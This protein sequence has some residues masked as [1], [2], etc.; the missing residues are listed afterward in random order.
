MT[1][2]QEVE[3][4]FLDQLEALGWLVIDQ[5][6][7]S[8]EPP[9]DPTASERYSFREVVLAERFKEAVRDINR[10]E[11]G[12]TWLTN[13]QLEQVLSEVKSVRCTSGLVDTNE[14][15]LQLLF[16]GAR[17]DENEVTGQ[18]SPPVH[19][20]D[21]QNPER[22]DFLAINQFRVDVPHGVKP[23]IIPDIV[24]FVNGLPLVVVE[25]KSPD[26]VAADALH[27]AFQQLMRYSDQRPETESA[28]LR[29][30]EPRLFQTNQLLIR[31]SGEYA[32]YGSITATDPEFFFPW[33]DIIPE[34][35]QDY[36]PPLGRERS[37]EVLIQGMLP[38]AT[39]LD[40]MRT[41]TVFMNSGPKRIKVV[42]RYQQ[43]RAVHRMVQR[44]RDGQTPQERSGV[45]WH[46]QGS[47]KSLTMVFLIRK[48]RVSEDLKDYKVLLVNDRR[49]LEK[50][51]GDTAALTGER[52]NWVESTN[53]LRNKLSTP[54]SDLNLVMIHKFHEEEDRTPGYMRDYS[55]NY[56]IAADSSVPEY[57]TFGTVN[58]SDRVLIL[59]DEAHR[60]QY[61]DMGD[62]L[63]EA[64]PNATRI[65][66]TGTPLI[67]RRGQKQLTHERF[68]SYIDK[69]KVQDAVDD[70]VT[71]QI[72][73]EGRTAET[74]ITH[75]HEFDT[76]FEDLFAERSDEEIQKIKKKYGTT[77]DILEAQARI[78][79]VAEDLVD[80]YIEHILPNGFKA[81][82]VANSKLAAVRYEQYIHKAL[83]NRIKQEK[84]KD[85]P[86]LNHVA[87][88]SF[89]D[90]A[91]VVSA[92]GTNER[93]EVVDADRRTRSKNAVDNFLKA[94]DR[95]I[96]ETGMAFLCVCDRLLT[97]FDAPIEQ[98]MYIDKK[99]RDH[100]LLQT[101]ARVNRVSEDKTRGY[102]VDY[103]G[104]AHHLKEMLSIYGGGEDQK[105]AEA[106]LQP[107]ENEVPLLEQRYRRLIQ[108]F[109]AGNVG[110]IESFA[111]QTLDSQEEAETI[112][113]AAI[114]YLADVEL[115]AEFEVYFKE[116]M[117]SL[118]IILPN[119]AGH[120]Y[121]IPAK[122]FGYINA[123]AKQRYK[124]E[125]LNL[126]GAGEKVKRLVD[127]HLVS[128]GIDPKIPPRELFSNDFIQE[129]EERENPRAKASEMEHA[130]RKH[131]KVHMEEDPALYRRLS[132]KLEQLIQQYHQ[133]W[134]R[135]YQEL[136]GLREEAQQ[137]RR[138]GEF[139]D[140]SAQEAPFYELIKIHAFGEQELS[141]KE[142][143]ALRKLV[144]A[145]FEEL[146]RTIGRVNFWQKPADVQALRGKLTQR[147]LTS[148]LEQVTNNRHQIAT[149]LVELAKNRERDILG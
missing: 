92:G 137:G 99:V 142:H 36:T 28:G 130:I 127:E 45:V 118:D 85:L 72:L 10:T 31:I 7:G 40:L 108:F 102:I 23:F 128:L 49:D 33:R 6:T 91:T 29:E 67:V 124:D 60:S 100:N 143:E 32:E 119:P 11:D 145:V 140:V 42:A 117:R 34:S 12:R 107:V 62:N 101:I 120:E 129:M 58:E 97:G 46:T 114:A 64:F 75:R 95:D 4:P 103:I 17:V 63:F 37:Q 93:A 116:F 52:V 68:G 115:R 43:Y 112:A 22:N 26:A 109:E 55:R 111:K 86:D 51:L 41:C 21:F 138:K 88:L 131:I 53:A 54:R 132:E 5:A 66:F 20:I 27:D 122:R 15:V 77:G 136:L 141:K 76:R 83:N 14:A 59:I 56:S 1:E 24:L 148:G 106:T 80:H 44:L 104:L 133:D 113:E 135:L 65:A 13:E 146:S 50:Q 61:S 2:Y 57:R 139:Q 89:L 19:L 74:A 35:Y 144:Q 38:P 73:Y 94:F 18:Q 79:A 82:V 30:G 105:D 39:L 110:N 70:G 25:C 69:Y 149:D 125:T 9:L 87:L 81:Q 3:K 96:P 134:E 8:G 98:V 47:G 126:E 121:R 123:E 71:V 84:A 90:I 48:L 16:E 147:L 78:E